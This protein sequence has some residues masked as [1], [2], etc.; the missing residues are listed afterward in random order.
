MADRISHTG[1]VVQI[2]GNI[3]KVRILQSSAC[4]GCEARKLC[5]SSESKEKEIDARIPFGQS[6]R[7]GE[8]VTVVGAL[9]MGR[10]A[11]ILAFVI[12]L[13]LIVAW[14]FASILWLK[15]EELI[16]IAIMFGL[17][18]IYYFVMWMLRNRIKKRFEFYIDKEIIV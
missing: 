2:D 6:V 14:M 3:A 12:P 8:N 17:L 16:A 10:N 7:I 13:I 5:N 18:A 4:S 9:S 15:M 1:T 11:V